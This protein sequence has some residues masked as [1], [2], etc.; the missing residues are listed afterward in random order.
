MYEYT[1][2]EINIIMKYITKVCHPD[3]LHLMRYF[4]LF[5]DNDIN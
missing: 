5:L 2:E 1:N 4:G 3:Q